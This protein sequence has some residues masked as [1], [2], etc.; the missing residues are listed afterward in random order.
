MLLLHKAV[1]KWSPQGYVEEQHEYWEEYSGPVAHAKGGQ[2][3]QQVVPTGP[4][5]QQEPFIM[6]LFNQGRNLLHQGMPGYFPGATTAP[7]NPN[8]VDS[9]NMTTQFIH[10]QLPVNQAITN[11]AS[12]VADQAWNN[13][14]ARFSS[15]LANPAQGAISGLLG[16]YTPGGGAA[17]A[18]AASGAS[19][20]ITGAYNANPTQF[21]TPVNPVGQ[22]PIGQELQRSLQGGALNPFLDQI[23]QGATR[24]M[25]RGFQDEILPGISTAQQGAGQFGGGSGGDVARGIAAS[26]LN[27]DIGDITSRIYG[28]AFDRG[29]DERMNAMN[30][31]SGAA[32]QNAALGLNT[33]ALTEQARQ[34]AVGQGLQGAQLALGAL[35]DAD[36]IRLQGTLGGSELATNA[37]GQGQNQALQQY[38][39]ALG[40]IPTMQQNS[41]N[42]M[43]TQNQYG[44][45]QYGLDQTGIDA[46][47]QRYWYEQM[48]PYN[49]LS[50]FQN[51]IAGSY[52]SSV[53][54]A[55]P[56]ARAPWYDPLGLF[57][58]GSPN[59]PTSINT[60]NIFDPSGMFGG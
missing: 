5:A 36:R 50:M 3:Q 33:Q 34:G 17:A 51:Y 14:L 35:T 19:G 49:A 52:G 24:G 9:R 31:I 29:A 43:G 57:T 18:G 22:V 6:E 7:I 2:A 58:G 10:D 30:L 59:I 53:P 41:L 21:Q 25:M 1:L 40:I 38:M 47:M 23:V 45:Q 13:P 12:N 26:R 4:W 11:S 39:A 42:M 44:L 54:N 55:T 48:A 16:G 60:R 8:L 20:A 46:N 27:Q 37:M 32:G 15:A 56:Q 28:Q